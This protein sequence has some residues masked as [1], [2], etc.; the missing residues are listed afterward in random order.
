MQTLYQSDSFIVVRFELPVADAPADAPTR[1]GY[2]LVDR[3]A[4]REIFLDG[5]LAE[6]FQQGV[7]ALVASNPTEEAFDEFFGRYSAL[8]QQPVNLH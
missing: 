7:Q 8:A 6:H 2:E 3:H 4:R 5:L 1:G